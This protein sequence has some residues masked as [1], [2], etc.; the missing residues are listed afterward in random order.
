MQLEESDAVYLADMLIAVRRV[1]KF[2]A[3]IRYEEFAEDEMRSMAV[4]R[5]FEVIGESARLLSDDFRRAYPA[6]PVRQ[7]IG[8]RNIIAHEYAEIDYR[9]LY[10]VATV[11]LQELIRILEDLLPNDA[12]IVG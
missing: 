1:R 5:A 2:T 4:E 10:R 3:G 7:M 11:D 9:L 12:G 6:L 8:L